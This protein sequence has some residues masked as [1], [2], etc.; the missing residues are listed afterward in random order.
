MSIRASAVVAASLVAACG[1]VDEADDTSNAVIGCERP[2]VGGATDPIVFESAILEAGTHEPIPA[3]MIDGKHFVGVQLTTTRAY[4]VT[5]LGAHIY[6]TSP[7]CDECIPQEVSM[8]IVPLDTST[9]LP[10]TNTL[11]DAICWT[12]GPIPY[13]QPVQQAEPFA[14]TVFPASFLLPAG[15]WGLV[16]A[17]N[18]FNSAFVEGL[19]PLDVTPVGT[20]SYFHYFEAEDAGAGPATGQWVHTMLGDHIRLFVVGH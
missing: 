9:N 14:S 6:T 20:P 12:V 4:A 3:R 8:A 17:S 16:I 18:R 1:G 19:L 13:V 5:G 15:S 11:S 10:K 2:D 7:P